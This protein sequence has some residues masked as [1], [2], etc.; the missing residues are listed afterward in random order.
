MKKSYY[1]PISLV[2]LAISI[3]SLI[4]YFIK[5]GPNSVIDLG[6]FIGVC[7]AFIGI[8]VTLLIGYQIY[9]VMEIKSKLS[10]IQILKDKIEE[11]KAKTTTQQN[12]LY[13]AIHILQSREPQLKNTYNPNAFLHFM[14]AIP[15]SLSLPEKKEGYIELLKELEDNMMHILLPSFGSGPKEVFEK[16]V[17]ELRKLYLETDRDIRNHANYW[18][19]KDK[20][21]DLIKKFEKRLD[22][23]SQKKN[24]SLWHLDA[25]SGEEPEFKHN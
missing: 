16:G 12:E 18:M 4:L 21:E 1:L 13:E 10:D 20:Y 24:P 14:A 25:I 3:V 11:I 22:I 2:S 5:V 9:N 17:K 15:Y 6:T 8:S 19:I 7:A 23:I